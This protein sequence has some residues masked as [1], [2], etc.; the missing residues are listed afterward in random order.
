MKRDQ[1]RLS[2]L[3][4]C[5]VSRSEIPTCATNHVSY[6]LTDTHG[7]FI[8]RTQGQL[9]AGRA[10]NSHCVVRNHQCYIVLGESCLGQHSSIY[11]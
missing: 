9:K 5:C 11:L 2:Q 1:E 7:E 4:Y 6:I 8:I 3:L 10:V